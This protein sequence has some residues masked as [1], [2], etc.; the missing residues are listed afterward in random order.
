MFLIKKLHYLFIY[1]NIRRKKVE[2]KYAK[3]MAQQLI[4]F[5]Y[6]N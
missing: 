3:I 1:F 2:K 6:N 4:Y 5:Y